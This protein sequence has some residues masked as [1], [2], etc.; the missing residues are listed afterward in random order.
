M[1]HA[2][3]TWVVLPC[4]FR[5]A[6]VCW[7]L[8][9]KC[10]WPYHDWVV[11]PHSVVSRYYIIICI[12]LL[13][14]YLTAGS[15]A[16]FDSNTWEPHWCSTS[17]TQDCNM[18]LG[19]TLNHWGAR[20]MKLSGLSISIEI[21]KHPRIATLS[22]CHH[23]D[24]N[25]RHGFHPALTTVW[26]PSWIHDYYTGHFPYALVCWLFSFAFHRFLSNELTASVL[27]YWLPSGK[28]LIYFSSLL[29]KVGNV[30]Q[31]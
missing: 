1:F 17:S 3:F 18:R 2:N 8:D 16:A 11:L 10:W 25:N 29:T 4:L 12:F 22:C 23:R 20:I 19:H 24:R 27:I 9:R 13:H 26:S 28:H 6:W 31:Y 14:I 7:K 5:I 15:S 30:L 21:S